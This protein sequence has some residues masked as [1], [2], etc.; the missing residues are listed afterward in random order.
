MSDADESMDNWRQFQ[1]TELGSLL[2]SIYGNNRP[3]INYPKPKSKAVLQDNK[4][5]F[6]PGGAKLEAS[7]PRKATRKDVKIAIPKPTGRSVEQENIKPIDYIPKRKGAAA[8][9]HD[10][11]DIRM[12]QEHYRPAFVKPVAIDAEKDRLSQIFTFKGGKALPEGFTMPIGEAPFEVQQ[13]KKEME[14]L[15][16]IRQKRGLMVVRSN[17]Q[18]ALSSNEQMAQHIQ[19]EIEER[20]QHLEEM[21][22]IG[23]NPQKEKSMMRDLA[24]RVD[25]LNRLHDDM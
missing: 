13:R 6:I 4:K 9:Q 3:K 22:K 14:R 25:E 21:R 20:T 5:G 2:G 11:D 8:I 1:G 24:Q 18:R 16:T 12:R 17:S 7:D 15:D 19:R 23:L 10:L